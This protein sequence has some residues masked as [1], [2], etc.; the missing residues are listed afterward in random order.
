[1]NNDNVSFPIINSTSLQK[2]D[3]VEWVNE[4]FYTRIKVPFIIVTSLSILF[5][6]IVLVSLI[7]GMRIVSFFYIVEVS[8]CLIIA[9]C[10][11]FLIP[12]ALAQ[13]RY[14]QSCFVNKDSSSKRE[15]F[16]Y[17][18]HLEL[19]AG[20]ETLTRLSYT[21]IKKIYLSEHLFIIV[22]P[23]QVNCIVRLD[24]FSETDFQIIQTRIHREMGRTEVER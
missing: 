24:G 17:K 1:M 3:F 22:F 8:V 16:F 23:K 18:D 12:N 9:L 13:W 20:D 15:V 5:Y 14:S 21:F 4:I 7:L 2:E 10:F 19:R 6:T 11:R